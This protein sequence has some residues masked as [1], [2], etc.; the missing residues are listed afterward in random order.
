MAGHP[1]SVVHNS[2]DVAG[3]REMFRKINQIF[4]EVAAKTI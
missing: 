3:K 1:T 4:A 2:R